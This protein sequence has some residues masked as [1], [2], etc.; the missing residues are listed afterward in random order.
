MNGVSNCNLSLFGSTLTSTLLP[1]SAGA[2]NP[3][4]PSSNPRGGNS[5]PLGASSFTFSPFSFTS[6]SVIGLKDKLP[7]IASAVVISGDATNA[8]VSGFPSFRFAKFLLNEVTIVFL[9][10]F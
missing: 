8:S 4:L 2:T 5:S 10:L 9:S 6:S 3:A 7:A 1:S